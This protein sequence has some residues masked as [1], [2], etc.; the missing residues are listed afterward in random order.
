M[1]TQSNIPPDLT[2]SDI[3]SIVQQLDVALNAG[4]F[5]SQLNG[6]YI[7]FSLGNIHLI[8]VA[9]RHIHRSCRCYAV[10]YL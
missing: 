8:V 5:D 4:I 7:H 1:A 2:D 3:A 6:V 9:H 10:E